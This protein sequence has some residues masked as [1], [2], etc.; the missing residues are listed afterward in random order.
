MPISRS[1][2]AKPLACAL[3][4]FALAGCEA[5]ISPDGDPELCRQ[6]PYPESVV[7]ERVVVRVIESPGPTE[8]LVLDRLR[9]QA[10]ADQ[11][12]FNRVIFATTEKVRPAGQGLAGIQRGDTLQVST[13]YTSFV[14]GGGYEAYI[15]NWAANEGDCWDGRWVSLH[16]LESVSRSAP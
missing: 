4:A 6:R 5:M 16:T 10:P 3:A 7:N 9:Y 2:L 8:R 13:T 14:R 12:N 1:S 11:R 15:S